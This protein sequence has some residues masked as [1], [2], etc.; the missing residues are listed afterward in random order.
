VCPHTQWFPSI[1]ITWISG[2]CETKLGYSTSCYYQNFHYF[3]YSRFS[4]FLKKKVQWL[5]SWYHS[6]RAASTHLCW[7]N[8]KLWSQIEY[9]QRFFN[10]LLNFCFFKKNYENFIISENSIISVE[11]AKVLWF[12]WDNILWNVAYSVNALIYKG[13]QIGSCLGVLK[14]CYGQWNCWI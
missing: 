3:N 4:W 5:Y 13:F 8:N 11:A 9:S 2:T 6:T 1:G 12:V 10:F 14:K 7:I